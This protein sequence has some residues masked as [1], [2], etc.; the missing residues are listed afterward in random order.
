MA[1]AVRLRLPRS[2]AVG[3]ASANGRISRTPQSV[4]SYYCGPFTSASFFPRPLVWLAGTVG[5]VAYFLPAPTPVLAEEAA[6]LSSSVRDPLSG[7]EFPISLSPVHK[8]SAQ[9]QLVGL[10]TRTVTFLYISVYTVGLYVDAKQL[11]AAMAGNPR[12]P[13]LSP[14]HLELLF[15]NHAVDMTLRVSPV[16]EAAFSHMRDGFARALE[17]RTVGLTPA[18]RDNVMAEILAFKQLFPKGNF[19]VGDVLL[20]STQGD[21]VHLQHND[22]VLGVVK[23]AFIA[24]ALPESY[25]DSAPVS[26]NAKASIKNGF[27]TLQC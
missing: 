22:V 7:L 24:R 6:R 21:T 27:E 11:T 8:A 16:R 2:V 14:D 23:S 18:Q 15:K 5:A 20:M 26:T 19:S 25:L 3:A 1:A 4:R 12:P 13:A 9:Q 10:G 17:K